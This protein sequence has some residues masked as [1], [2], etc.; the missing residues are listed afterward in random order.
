MIGI[1]YHIRQIQH[2]NLS[3]KGGYLRSGKHPVVVAPC[4]DEGGD[5]MGVGGF[6]DLGIA[7]FPL[8]SKWY[9]SSLPN[10]S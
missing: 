5:E 10:Q 1:G 6:G 7:L 8:N 3:E 9:F 2:V 4:C